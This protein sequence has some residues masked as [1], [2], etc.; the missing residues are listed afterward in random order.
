MRA[1]PR[2]LCLEVVDARAQRG[3]Q[4]LLRPSAATSAAWRPCRRPGDRRSIATRPYSASDRGG[5]RSS[6]ARF[7]APTRRR[8]SRRLW[9]DFGSSPSRRTAASIRVA[10]HQSV[11]C[12]LAA[13]IPDQPVRL[14]HDPVLSRR[15]DR[16]PAR[17]RD[18]RAQPRVRP[19][20]VIRPQVDVHRPVHRL[21][22]LRRPRRRSPAAGRSGPRR[23]C[24]SCRSSS[25]PATGRGTRPCRG[26]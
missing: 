6:S 26:P 1:G 25:A 4:L 24:R 21:D 12:E 10:G 23:R 20:H 16:R 8:R 3:Q 9:R 18:E 22:K 19:D 13:A 17:R 11:R 5:N 15:R 7:G 14:G 2:D